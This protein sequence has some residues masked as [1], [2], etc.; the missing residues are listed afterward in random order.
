M[1]SWDVVT[2]SQKKEYVQTLTLHQF[3]EDLSF[4]SPIQVY[5]QC[6]MDIPR[7]CCYYGTTRITTLRHLDTLLRGTSFDLETKFILHQLCT[8]TSLALA[9]EH[10][11]THLLPKNTH[12]GSGS[13]AHV[14]KIEEERVVIQ[15]LF[16]VFEI[17]GDDGSI[18]VDF[19][20][21]RVDVSLGGTVLIEYK[22]TG[23]EGG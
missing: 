11:I 9:T 16:R 13:S 17:G 15:K 23:L 3:T 18:T 4:V 7:M 12:L 20:S 22:F 19:L 6:K 14:V 1:D 10:A 8:Q 5:T 21:I 2:D